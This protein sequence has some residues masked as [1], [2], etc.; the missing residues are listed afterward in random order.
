VYPQ[1][2]GEEKPHAERRGARGRE[3][4]KL[5]PISKIQALK[6]KDKPGLYY[7]YAY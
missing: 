3:V 4:P 2:Y 1:R 6:I 5:Q 7:G